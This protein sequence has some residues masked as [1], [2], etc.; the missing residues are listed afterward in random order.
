MQCGVPSAAVVKN[1]P[2]NSGEL[3]SIPGSGRSLGLGND[4]QLH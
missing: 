4:K 3:G 2:A 1:P